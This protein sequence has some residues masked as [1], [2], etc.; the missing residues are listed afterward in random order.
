MKLGLIQGR[1]SPPT[2]GFQDTPKDWSLEFLKLN[3]LGLEHIEWIITKESFNNNP[4][5]TENLKKFP[6]FSVC[7][8]NLVDENIIDFDFVLPQLEPICL[9]ALKNNVNYVTIPLLE[10]SS[11]I[12]ISKRNKFKKI[13]GY[14]IERF[15]GIKFSIEAEMPF[16]DL[17]E[18]LCLSKNIYVTYDTGNMT[19]CGYNHKEYINEV[20]DRISNVHLKDRTLSGQT[21]PPLR[22][23]TNFYD[24]FKILN[25]N[26]YKG[27][28]TLQTAREKDGMEFSTIKKHSQILR[29]IY[30]KCF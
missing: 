27:S 21:V 19:S 4:F 28:F 8:D 1:L 5:F 6:I 30:E 2:E 7:A 26:N 29:S 25:N 18:I 10:D 24:I 9:F 3:E 14:F 13:L 16:N 20:F 15:P 12:N 17:K 22:G 23:D 11:L